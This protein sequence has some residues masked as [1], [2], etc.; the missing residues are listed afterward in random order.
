MHYSSISLLLALLCSALSFLVFTVDGANRFHH[1]HNLISETLWSHPNWH[2][3]G[4]P[5]S[6]GECEGGFCMKSVG[7]QRSFMR[8]HLPVDTNVVD[9]Y[10]HYL[11]DI[12]VTTLDQDPFVAFSGNPS[13]VVFRAVDAEKKPIKHIR[14][15][16]YLDNRHGQVRFQGIEPILAGTEYI[17]IALLLRTGGSWRIDHV[18]LHVIEF[19]SLYRCS[20]Y[21]IFLAWIVCFVYILYQLISFPVTVENPVVVRHKFLPLVKAVAV[22]MIGL[23]GLVAVGDFDISIRGMLKSARVL[24]YADDGVSQSRIGPV[25][26]FGMHAT[27]HGVLTLYMYLFRSRLGLNDLRVFIIN[28]AMAVGIESVQ[29]GI[30]GRSADFADIGSAGVGW[31]AALLAYYLLRHVNQTLYRLRS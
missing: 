31:L 27:S 11:L 15:I 7:E 19:S 18:G 30:P 28:V 10:D 6:F 17:R 5:A 22:V 16:G 3:R 9:Q 12:R 20:R 23:L 21:S 24:L 8:L 1:T 25:L 14:P 4:D 26:E 2:V 13:A 29:L